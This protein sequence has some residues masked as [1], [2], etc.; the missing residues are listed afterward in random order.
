MHFREQTG[1]VLLTSV[2][3]NA[4]API[5]TQAPFPSSHLRWADLYGWIDY[6]VLIHLRV[7]GRRCVEALLAL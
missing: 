7:Y 4:P 2:K 5:Q 3:E 6:A 1:L